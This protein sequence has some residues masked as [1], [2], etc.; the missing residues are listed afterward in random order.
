MKTIKC[1][2]LQDGLLQCGDGEFLLILD[3]DEEI[4]VS[5][6]MV[7]KTRIDSS[8][9]DNMLITDKHI[10]VLRSYQFII[11]KDVVLIPPKRCKALVLMVSKLTNYGKISMTGRG[12]RDFGQ[13]ILLYVDNNSVYDYIPAYTEL[14]YSKGSFSTE[15]ISEFT[16][17]ITDID[18]SEKHGGRGGAGGICLNNSSLDYD[19]KMFSSS[20]AG[21][22]GIQPFLL[23]DTYYS[24][25][26]VIVNYGKSGITSTE[27]IPFMVLASIGAVH[28]NS[29][30]YRVESSSSVNKGSGGTLIIYS[31]YFENYG[32]IESKGSN[33]NVP[34]DIYQA[35]A[36][37]VS[38]GPSGGGII[39]VFYNHVF[40]E[41]E[42]SEKYGEFR[43]SERYK[44]YRGS[45]ATD[46]NFY[47]LKADR[48]LSFLGNEIVVESHLLK[49]L[50]L[51][52]KAIFQLYVQE[53]FKGL[54]DTDYKAD[55]YKLLFLTI[56]PKMDLC[57]RCVFK[58]LQ[59]ET[60]T[61]FSQYESELKWLRPIKTDYFTENTYTLFKEVLEE[62][63]RLHRI[64][65]QEKPEYYDIY[66]D[67]LFQP[68]YNVIA[69][70]YLEFDRRFDIPDDYTVVSFTG[71][72]SD[73]HFYDKKLK[74]IKPN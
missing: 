57:R 34:T 37:I 4:L 61:D 68:L 54:K 9:F 15:S 35:P 20:F 19:I 8:V 26:D 50:Y 16:M 23:V 48:Q 18:S 6:K 69:V 39:N 59:L 24:Y 27:D 66:R 45:D 28:K 42:H 40:I 30:A 58:N 11:E 29:V 33:S 25:E 65:S 43:E 31:N 41:G 32:I 52:L 47:S 7:P 3:N 53:F 71:K 62:L 1:H 21:G 10:V 44:V 67:V 2:T 49:V 63:N 5:S 74:T 55:L 73:I 60:L 64:I 51:S 36:Y 46:G 72:D 70:L 56:Y 14:G 22:A 12:S 17:D 13:D 38:G